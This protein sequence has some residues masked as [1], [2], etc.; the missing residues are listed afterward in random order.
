MELN[1]V[2]KDEVK[3]RRRNARK[4]C[5]ACRTAHLTCDDGRPCLR[6]IK[7]GRADNCHEDVSKKLGTRQHALEKAQRSGLN[8]RNNI[9]YTTTSATTSHTLIEDSRSP[10]CPAC[11]QY[12][13]ISPMRLP[14]DSCVPGLEALSSVASEHGMLGDLRTSDGTFGNNIGLK[15][16]Q[17]S[18]SMPPLSA[19]TYATQREACDALFTILSF[20]ESEPVYSNGIEYT[21]IFGLWQNLSSNHR[22][23]LPQSDLQALKMEQSWSCSLTH[24]KQF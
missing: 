17:P 22:I 3:P 12:R 19:S 10:F 13:P 8:H 16:T 20:L 15:I 24:L 6:C 7:R 23:Q 18:F 9:V 1:S 11:N 14:P 5:S 4:A 21:I 2:P